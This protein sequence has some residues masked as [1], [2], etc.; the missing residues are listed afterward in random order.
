MNSNIIDQTR[1]EMPFVY[2]EHDVPRIIKVIGV[3]GGGGNAVSRMFSEESIDGVSFLLCNTDRQVLD[4]SPVPNK[5]CIGPNITKGL[6]AGNKPERAREAAE[7]SEADIRNALTCD[8]TEMV[9]ITAGMGGGTGTGAAPVLGRIAREEGKLTIGIVTIPFLFE[10][11]KKILKALQGVQEMEKYTDAILVI[12]NQRLCN[13][14][15]DLSIEEAFEKADSTLRNATWSISD[16]INKEGKINLDFNDVSTTLKDG[17]VAVIS[18]GEG[19]GE[20]R[21]NHAINQALTSPL[22]NN[23]NVKMAKRLL[24]YVY[25]SAEQP[26]VTA[27]LAA[28][29]EFISSFGDD[30]DCIWGLAHPTDELRGGKVRV[31]ILASGFDYQTTEDSILGKTTVD[32]IEALDLAKKREAEN[33]LIERHYGPNIKSSRNITPLILEIDELDDDDILSFAEN[34]PAARRDIKLVEAIRAKRGSSLSHHITSS[35]YDNIG[36][37]SMEQRQIDD[38]EL[39][40]IHFG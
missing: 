37:T 21:L 20:D 15:G 32:S 33:A 19:E 38:N 35:I 28:I 1:G 8:D 10:G 2:K 24:I 29:E 30:V 34:T 4:K 25:M 3:G 16:M 7:E 36:S 11:K 26:L 18:F 27:E 6:G 5:I 9:F 31:T 40:I 17:G 12:N 22:V 39:D 23:N 14:Y 13:I